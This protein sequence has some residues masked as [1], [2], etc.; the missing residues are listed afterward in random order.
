MRNTGRFICA[1]L[2]VVGFGTPVVHVQFGSGASN[3]WRGN[4]GLLG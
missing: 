3:G 4:H 1:F 2:L